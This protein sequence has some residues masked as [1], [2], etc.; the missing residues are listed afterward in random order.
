MNGTRIR[1]FNEE[2]VEAV[3]LFETVTELIQEIFRTQLR[4]HSSKEDIHVYLSTRDTMIIN[5]LKDYFVGCDV[6]R[7]WLLEAIVGNRERFMKFVEK[8]K[9]IYKSKRKLVKKF[10]DKGN[11]DHSPAFGHGP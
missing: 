3:K 7:D 6:S 11:N 2:S 5:L 9:D 1:R 4:N 8:N 10:I